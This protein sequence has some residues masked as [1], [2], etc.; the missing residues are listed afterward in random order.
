MTALAGLAALVE[1][2]RA[3]EASNQA[4]LIRFEE[5]QREV[6]QAAWSRVWP[7]K[8]DALVA[9]LAVLDPDGDPESYDE[10]V[11]AHAVELTLT[12]DEEVE[13]V[14]I[15]AQAFA[16]GKV[17]IL[18]QAKA[19]GRAVRSSKGLVAARR[20][21]RLE[22]QERWPRPILRAVTPDEVAE[23]FGNQMSVAMT[24]RDV[25]MANWLAQD[26][27]FWIR[28]SWSQG[29]GKEIAATSR[30]VALGAGR[31]SD[32]AA[33]L[34]KRLGAQYN[35]PDE[36]WD[37]MANATVQRGRSMGAISGFNA[38]GASSFRFQSVGDERVSPV[39]KS[40]HGT[41]FTVAQAN[42][43]V[44]AMMGAQDPD[45][46]KAVSPWPKATDIAGLSA[47]ELAAA[48]VMTPPL[49]GR[50]RSYLVIES[51]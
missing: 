47:S 34:K 2:G 12:R 25:R 14:T 46:F 16:V 11:A 26:S 30:S 15:A 10:V 21:R 27:M 37:V 49:H 9:D 50:C 5:R 18:E 4:A 29:L 32:V 3:T 28:D 51:F 8:V 19:V 17:A 6:A 40:L 31:Q 38:A 36:Y 35:E 33:A 39:C 42:D 1:M 20:W 22:E 24:V 43:H 41:V 23:I 44:D 7:G 13:V 48:G 45:E